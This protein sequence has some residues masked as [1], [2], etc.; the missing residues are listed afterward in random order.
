MEANISVFIRVK[1]LTEEEKGVQS[2]QLWKI[3]DDNTIALAKLSQPIESNSR[4]NECT[5]ATK[6]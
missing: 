5:F 4:T 1:P 2:N 3:F 6:I